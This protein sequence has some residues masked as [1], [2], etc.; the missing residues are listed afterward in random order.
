VKYIDA[1][2]GRNGQTLVGMAHG[3]LVPIVLERRPEL[4]DYVEIAYEQLRHAPRSA[5]IQLSIPAVL[6]CASMSVAGFVP[7]TADALTAISSEAQRMRTP[8]IGEHLAFISADPLDDCA[9]SD[10]VSLTYTVCPQLSEQ[11]VDRVVH[12]MNRL[13]T[14]IPVPIIVENSPQYFRMPGSTM[15][16]TDFISAVLNRCPIGLLL[17]LT[18]FLIT[19]INTAKDPRE[20]LRLLPLE[21][22]VEMHISGISIQSGIAWDDHASAAPDA[23]FDLLEIVC[24]RSHPRAVT[25]EYNWATNLPLEVIVRQIG[26]TRELVSA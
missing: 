19:C 9:G 14:E 16:M 13:R 1:D 11:T 2:I 24:E 7:P 4:I 26:S 17:D 5:A 18:H 23:I 25:F 3:P 22:V 6:H 21:R 20:E 10:P 15:S 12:N 8:W